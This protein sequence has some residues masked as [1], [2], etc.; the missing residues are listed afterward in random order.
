M[1]YGLQIFRAD[2]SL[3]LDI[4]DRLTRLVQQGSGVFSGTPVNYRVTMT[5]PVPGLLPNS[6]WVVV[7]STTRTEKLMGPT[8]YDGYFTVSNYI[9]LG[10]NIFRYAVFRR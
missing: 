4:S 9:W 6:E 8:I 3:K 10:D 1:A 2:G 7:V 5:V